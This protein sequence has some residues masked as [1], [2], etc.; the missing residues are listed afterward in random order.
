[1]EYLQNDLQQTYSLK[2]PQIYDPRPRDVCAVI[3]DGSWHRCQLITVP[4]KGYTAVR[5]VDQGR[6]KVVSIKA[7]RMLDERHA[8]L[9]C[10]VTLCKLSVLQSIPDPSDT[11][12]HQKIAKRFKAICKM[13][14]NLQIYVKNVLGTFCEVYLYANHMKNGLSVHAYMLH[15]NYAVFNID[16][17][18]KEYY[19]KDR[20]LTNEPI[21]EKTQPRDR[22]FES[23]TKLLSAPKTMVQL[24][25]IES[26]AEIYIC[27]LKINSKYRRLHFN[28]QKLMET[29]YVGN[30][31]TDNWTVG[32]QCLVYVKL[33][34][35]DMPSW[36]RA[37][38][39]SF[40][41]PDHAVIFLREAAITMSILISNLIPL[42]GQLANIPDRSVRCHLN[43][44]SGCENWSSTQD[45]IDICAKFKKMAVSTDDRTANGSVSVMLWGV[46]SIYNDSSYN[47]LSD[48]W[49]LINSCVMEKC[50]IRMTQKFLAQSN[51]LEGSTYT[52]DYDR[53]WELPM[54]TNQ[55]SSVFVLDEDDEL[56]A[57][58][59]KT[60]GFLYNFELE[61]AEV[62]QWLPAVPHTRSIFTVKPTYV[63]YKG[64]INAQTMFNQVVARKMKHLIQQ[65]VLCMEFE[66]VVFNWEENQ[67]C[68]ARYHADNHFYRSTVLR[69]NK[70]NCTCVVSLS[71]GL[72]WWV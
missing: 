54:A 5:L 51:S 13:G 47:K 48:E 40:E 26:P 59:F 3:V 63:N 35:L 50:V 67:P 32:D 64:V 41:D 1:M 16:L 70:D 57:F 36:Y 6:K 23:P 21:N 24:V 33:S 8:R 68:L 45:L 7:M 52:I 49:I 14:I 2:L 43:G 66:A 30:K 69:V 39:I 55:L 11:K 17:L 34:D 27:P 61:L 46:R 56:E 44:L 4:E 10:L 29:N 42:V 20:D 9:P 28:I 31:A 65:R 12:Y 62:T 60:E 25:H 71:V 72:F 58:L 15:E 38:L 19:G 18:Q 53:D 22:N 37:R